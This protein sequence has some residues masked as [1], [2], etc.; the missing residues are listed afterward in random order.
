MINIKPNYRASPEILKIQMDQALCIF[1]LLIL[2]CSLF[3]HL[4]VFF[5]IDFIL[6]PSLSFL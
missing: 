3:F 4:A 2:L 5:L 6:Y 1:L